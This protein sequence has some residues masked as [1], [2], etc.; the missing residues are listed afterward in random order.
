MLS[1]MDLPYSS[2]HLHDGVYVYLMFSL[3]Q[4]EWGPPVGL[5]FLQMH[6]AAP[7]LV[8][9]RFDALDLVV[10]DWVSY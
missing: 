10:T 4:Q 8:S 2:Q 6:L 1:F 7:T 5:L 3:L 9:N